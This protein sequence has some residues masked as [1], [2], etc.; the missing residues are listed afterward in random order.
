MIIV[1]KS[2]NPGGACGVGF[3]IS[4]ACSRL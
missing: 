1:F 4:T 2:G 3:G